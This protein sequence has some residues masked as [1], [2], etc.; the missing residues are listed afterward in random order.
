MASQKWAAW[1]ELPE[2]S[3]KS[4]AFLWAMAIG[5]P[6]TFFFFDKDFSKYSPDFEFEILLPQLLGVQIIGLCYYAWLCLI[7]KHV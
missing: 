4:L 1:H 7:L 3:W 5:W 6:L 2:G